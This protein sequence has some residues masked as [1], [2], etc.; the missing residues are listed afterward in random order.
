M[1]QKKSEAS[2]SR[3][4]LAFKVEGQG[5]DRP[6]TSKLIFVLVENYLS[7]KQVNCI[8]TQGKQ[9]VAAHRV[10][11]NKSGHDSNDTG[12]PTNGINKSKET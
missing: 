12:I 1:I 8:G 11:Q 3:A 10:F 6:K 4:R 7:V 5:Y 2:G 9:A